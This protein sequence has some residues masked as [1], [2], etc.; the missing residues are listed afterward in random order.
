M[1]DIQVKG[2]SKPWYDSDI[3]EALRVRDKLKERFLRTKLHV[4][5]EHFK[6]QRSSLQQKIKNKKTNFVRNQLQKNIKK[7][8]ELW[9]VLQNIGLPSKA[10]NIKNGSHNLMTNKMQTLLRT[11]TQ[12]LHQIQSKNF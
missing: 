2:N 9:K 8:K 7:S 11:F 1:K 4:G 6:E 5:Q 10:P 12:S 3:M